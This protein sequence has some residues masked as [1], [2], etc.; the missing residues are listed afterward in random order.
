MSFFVYRR[1]TRFAESD[2]AGII[3]F[4]RI[5]QFVEEAEHAF[6][7]Q[8]GF[9]VWDSSTDAFRWPRVS[10][11]ATYS[12]PVFPMETVLIE[13]DPVR[14]GKSSITWGWSL[15]REEPREECARGEMK[16]VCCRMEQG[17][18][19]SAPIPENLRDALTRGS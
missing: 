8:E 16:T 12:C 14:I 11:S 4:S 3:H 15:W 19:V 1:K 7:E 2:A 13:L 17:G 6:L 18:L 9:P 10:Y 5:A